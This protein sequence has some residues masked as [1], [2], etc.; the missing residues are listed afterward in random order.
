MSSFG[1]DMTC[2]N[3]VVANKANQI[4]HGSGANLEPEDM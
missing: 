3:T 2:G 1:N 4:H